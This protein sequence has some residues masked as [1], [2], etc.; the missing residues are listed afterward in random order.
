MIAAVQIGAIVLFLAMTPT[1]PPPI[2]AETTYPLP[3]YRADC[4]LVDR[5][6]NLIKARIDVSGVGETRK[7]HIVLKSPKFPELR[8]K[9]IYTG[10]SI[11]VIGTEKWASVMD[12]Q[13]SKAGKDT[14]YVWIQVGS[15]F[16]KGAHFRLTRNSE[17]VPL[18]TGLCT[19]KPLATSS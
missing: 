13:V 7:L 2:P 11:R 17:T 5:E 10:P 15:D 9:L 6:G 14:E 8:N 18:V 12:A 4:R 16:S 1:P 19:A 3:Q